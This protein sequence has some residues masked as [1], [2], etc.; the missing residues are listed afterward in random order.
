MNA[1][2][3]VCKLK[4]LSN[5]KKADADGEDDAIDDENIQVEEQR[6]VPVKKKAKL[7]GKAEKA[8]GTYLDKGFGIKK[9]RL[10]TSVPVTIME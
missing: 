4:K 10:V 9:A 7:T 5:V 6:E 1:G 2:F 3:F 8:E